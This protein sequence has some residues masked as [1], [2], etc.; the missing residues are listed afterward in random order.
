ME[1]K[2]WRRLKAQKFLHT[3]AKSIDENIFKQALIDRIVN[4][5]Q[6]TEDEFNKLVDLHADQEA[7]ELA[8]EIAFDPDLEFDFKEEV[9]E[10]PEVIVKAFIK[11]AAKN[12]DQVW[13]Q[14]LVR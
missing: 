2:E 11:V 10:R 12:S 4:P 14:F 9:R 6:E 1:H 8:I 7:E 13:D 5:Q 3:A